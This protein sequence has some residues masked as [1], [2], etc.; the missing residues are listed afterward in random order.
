[1][2]WCLWWFVMSMLLLLLLLLL[3]GSLTANSSVG[4]CIYKYSITTGSAETTLLAKYVFHLQ[5]STFPLRRPCGRRYSRARVTWSVSYFRSRPVVALI[6]VAQYILR[7]YRITFR[8][9][10]IQQI[11]SY[12]LRRRLASE[13]TVPLGVM[14]SRCVCVFRAA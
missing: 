10:C 7:N 12:Y 9:T 6:W 1:M 11:Y 3:K 14:L 13:Y 2:L 4:R 8:P 5:K